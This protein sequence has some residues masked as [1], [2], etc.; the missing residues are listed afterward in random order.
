[1]TISSDSTKTTDSVITY[2]SEHLTGN[3][4]PIDYD[5]NRLVHTLTWETNDNEE[6]ENITV[7][8]EYALF[9]EGHMIIVDIKSDKAGYRAGTD[10][11]Q[12]LKSFSVED[13]R[14]LVAEDVHNESYFEK[15]GFS[16]TSERG[17]GPTDWSW[18][19]E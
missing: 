19:D 17:D 1:M 4:T 12:C 11:I 5:P 18:Q 8:L 10:L 15:L 13:S 2:L 7:T 3:I 6:K 16:P 14:L 9:G